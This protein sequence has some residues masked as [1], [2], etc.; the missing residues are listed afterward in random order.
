M[1]N[2]KEANINI[3]PEISETNINIER[4]EEKRRKNNQSKTSR[5]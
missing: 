2:K 4:K 3:K 1:W 5:N